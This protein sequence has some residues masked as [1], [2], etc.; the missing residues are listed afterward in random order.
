MRIFLIIPTL[1]SGGAERVMSELANELAIQKNDVYLVVLAESNDFYTINHNVKI[2]RLGFYNK[3]KI[4]KKAAEFRTLFKLRQLLKKE[5]PDAVLSFMEKYNIV[6]ILASRFLGLK[7]FVSDRSNPKKIL[8]KYIEVL[9]NLTYRYTT[10]IVAQTSLA[11]E[12]LEKATLNKNIKVIPNPI[13]KVQLYAEIRRQKIILNIGRLVPEKGHKYLLEVF[14]KL[15]VTDWKLVI[16]GDGPLKNELIEQAKELRIENQLIMPGTVNNV[17]EWFAKSSI[18]AFTSLS[19][20]F[21][22]ALVEAMAA[23]LPCVSFDC[24]AGPRDIIIDGENGFLDLENSVSSFANKIEAL[25][26]NNKLREKIGNNAKQVI[27]QYNSKDI[28]KKYINFL[29]QY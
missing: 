4:Q 27:S 5:K 13:R 20:G 6:T 8:P 11:K 9:R 26:R 2:H 29:K 3:G 21:P 23:G 7:V 28:S 19:E 22:N 1:T 16:L 15:N 17:D 24:D 14:H 18:F 25:I 10:G 12:I